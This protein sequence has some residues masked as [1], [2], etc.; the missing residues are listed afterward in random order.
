[1]ATEKCSACDEP[2]GRAGSADDSLYTAEGVGPFC[3]SCYDGARH[4]ESVYM[5]EVKRW[6]DL[7]KRNAEKLDLSSKRGMEAEARNALL[8]KVGGKLAEIVEREMSYIDVDNL[9][10]QLKYR[11]YA[12]AVCD[13]R[14]A[15]DAKE[16]K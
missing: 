2:T 3:L 15:L 5:T 14:A 11:Q 8:E 16:G 1:M 7:A 12:S 4:V 6:K 10:T 9:T 13:Y